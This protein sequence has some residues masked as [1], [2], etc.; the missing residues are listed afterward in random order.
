MANATA[1]SVLK[2]EIQTALIEI[3]NDRDVLKHA[4]IK[5]EEMQLV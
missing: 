4:D 1:T 3:G 5:P 2:K